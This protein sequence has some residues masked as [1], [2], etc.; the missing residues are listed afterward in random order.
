MKQRTKRKI[1]EDT[2]MDSLDL[3]RR[4]VLK[5]E[6]GYVDHPHDKGGPT[7]MGITVATYAA[8]YS[9]PYQEA[10]EELPNI[11]RIDAE[12][13]YH[14]RYW[15]PVGGSVLPEGINVFVADT[16]VNCGPTTA[17]RML[18]RC[19]PD[20]IID[21]GIMGPK[22]AYAAYEA[23]QGDLLRKYYNVRFNYYHKIA[24]RGNQSVFLRGWL[25]RLNH[26]YGVILKEI[27][28]I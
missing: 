24:K 19:L 3:F 21:D 25:N 26:M 1:L 7:N 2:T 4:E 11:T 10:L 14:Q 23:N 28:G 22:T 13:I 27:V 8:Y 6:G 17:I 12:E 20:D 5:A 16:A 18:Q 9:L 15:L